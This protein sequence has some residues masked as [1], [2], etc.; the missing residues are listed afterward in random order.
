MRTT[1]AIFHVHIYLIL[2]FS[3]KWGHFII[4]YSHYK[5]LPLMSNVY[6]SIV[7]HLHIDPLR[8]TQNCVDF[9]LTSVGKLLN[10]V[11]RIPNGREIMRNLSISYGCQ[12]KI[13]HF[14]C[15]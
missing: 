3:T 14:L 2:Y 12:F 10:K 9:S 4:I 5:V 1:A 15:S 7:C 11:V 8:K 13:M 6:A